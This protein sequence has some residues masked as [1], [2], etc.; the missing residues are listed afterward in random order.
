MRGELVR[1]TPTPTPLERRSA[2]AKKGARS[3]A[4]ASA[5]VDRRGSAMVEL[6]EL[7]SAIDHAEAAVQALYASRLEAWRAAV[8]SGMSIVAVAKAS[9]VTGPRVSQALRK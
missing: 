3:R 5:G 8:G 7:R 9:G 4:Q 6:E 1:G 2:A